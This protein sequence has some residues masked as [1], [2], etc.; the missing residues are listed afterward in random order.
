MTQP[1]AAG[2]IHLIRRWLDAIPEDHPVSS[3]MARRLLATPDHRTEM[4]DAEV[5][6]LLAAPPT[7]G[8]R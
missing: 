1:L 5:A 3:A 7:T 8:T 2:D 6:A 4:F